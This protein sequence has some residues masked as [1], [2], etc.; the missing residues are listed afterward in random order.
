MGRD[1]RKQSLK[2]ISSFGKA[3]DYEL[4]AI[5]INQLADIELSDY[6][7]ARANEVTNGEGLEAVAT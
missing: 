6:K 7:I 1:V 4:I 2:E 3:R 5:M